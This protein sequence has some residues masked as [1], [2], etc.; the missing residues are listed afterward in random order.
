MSI[1][2]YS[3]VFAQRNTCRLHALPIKITHPERKL[4]L[5]SRISDNSPA[6]R[7]LEGHLASLVNGLSHQMDEHERRQVWRA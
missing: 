6:S 5:L 3:V 7:R 2:P 1:L 4:G